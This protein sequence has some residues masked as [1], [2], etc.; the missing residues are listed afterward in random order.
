MDENHLQN[1]HDST[2][3]GVGVTNDYDLN[4]DDDM[5][6]VPPYGRQYLFHK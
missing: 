1:I 3:Y 2:Q 4:D 5:F 6:N